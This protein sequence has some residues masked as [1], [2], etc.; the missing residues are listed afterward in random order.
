MR[1]ANIQSLLSIKKLVEEEQMDPEVF[2]EYLT[3]LY[4][5]SQPPLKEHEWKSLRALADY[6]KQ[7]LDGF[8]L[9]YSIPQ[10]GKEFDLLWIGEHDGIKYLINIELKQEADQEEIKK[11]LLR[12]RYY[13][14]FSG[15]KLFLYSFIKSENTLYKL[16]GEK[17]TSITGE[18]LLFHISE[19]KADTTTDLD[20][21]FDPS[22]YLI[23]P[24]NTTEEFLKQEYFLTGQQEEI[25]NKILKFIDAPEG[26]FASITGAAGTGKTLLTYDIAMTLM[27]QGK[28]VLILHCASL[29]DGQNLLVEKHNWAIKCARYISINEVKNYDV[30]IIDEAQRMA[31]YQWKI[32]KKMS[33]KC[34]F[35]FDE[36]QY[37]SPKEKQSFTS[38]KIQVLSQPHNYKLTEKIRTNKE[39]ADFIKQLLDA[40]KN[41][42]L[43][44]GC[45]NI[46]VYHF[47]SKEEIISFQDIR[48]KSGWFIPKYTPSIYRTFHYEK[49]TL[50]N[51]PTAHNIIGQ[52]YDNVLAIIDNTFKYNEDGSF[53]AY[54]I[55]FLNT[56]SLERMFYQIV[57]RTRKKLCIAILNNERIFFRCLGILNRK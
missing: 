43:E 18:N 48:S 41:F 13:L 27:K 26:Y 11:Q 7:P 47:T 12:S 10:I 14:N 42:P 20:S 38:Q 32:A 15:R 51:S 52:E 8:Y 50:P 25:K 57:T 5:T 4:G 53:G 31:T 35:S 16:E 6:L 40:K 56:Y 23:S 44:R 22:N 3:H 28:R 49:Y 24:F 34:I 36:K 17:L 19:L 46:E 29:N 21:L 1:P 37:L 33:S 54:S 55:N 39:I 45:K 30:I 9:G 2:E